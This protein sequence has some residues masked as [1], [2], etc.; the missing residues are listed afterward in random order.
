LELGVAV[1]ND[2]LEQSKG[3]PVV[4]VR[5]RPVVDPFVRRTPRV[6][7]ALLVDVAGLGQVVDAVIGRGDGITIA[8]TRDG[9]AISITILSGDARPRGYASSQVELDELFAGLAETYII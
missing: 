8:R 1:G 4:A 6:A 3:K 9:G 2:K 5:V 7:D